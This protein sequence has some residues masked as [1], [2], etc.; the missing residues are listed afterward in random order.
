ML[1]SAISKSLSRRR[2]RFIQVM[3]YAT[4]T[5]KRQFVN[6]LSKCID[7]NLSLSYS[8]RLECQQI[9]DRGIRLF[10]PEKGGSYEIFNKRPLSAEISL[11][12][13]QDVQ[14]LPALYFAYLEKLSTKMSLRVTSATLDRVKE[15]Q[16]ALYVG[17]GQHKAR[18]PW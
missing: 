16:S 8:K 17:H 10:V 5:F 11:Y 4:R 12:C 14:W 3:E 2:S 6:G 13:V 7:R 18:G 15:S 9:K 1:F